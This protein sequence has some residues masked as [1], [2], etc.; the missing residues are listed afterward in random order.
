MDK[1]F[2]DTR[3]A[4]KE[5]AYGTEPNDFLKEVSKNIK[6]ASNILCLAEGEGRNAVFLAELGHKV[7]AIDYSE[8]G[9]K[10]LNSLAKNRNVNITGIC[11]DLNT[12]TV[13]ENTWDVI[14]CIFGHFPAPLRTKIL[15]QMYSGLREKGLFI[16]EAYSKQQLN[17]NTGGPQSL[18]LLYSI[19]EVANDLK[20]FQN[21]EIKQKER[22]ISEGKF[23]QGLSSVI[24]VIAGK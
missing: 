11:A 16:L 21:L 4:E 15:T 3:Y 17:Y 23:H 14:V 12:Y 8:S 6:P 5:F 1:S 7:T 24:Q 19:E 22:F 10:K 2:W 9:I 18:D 13:E 20:D